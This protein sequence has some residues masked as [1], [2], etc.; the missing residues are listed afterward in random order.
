ML[1]KSFKF[2]RVIVSSSAVLSLC[3]ASPGQAAGPSARPVQVDV[4]LVLAVDVSWSMTKRELEI[5]RRGYAEAL[6]SRAVAK[7]V[8]SGPIGRIALTYIEW[9]GEYWHRTIVDWTLIENQ[10]ALKNFAGSLTIDVS[11]EWRKT[12]ISGAIDYAVQKLANNRFTSLRQ[13]IDVSGDGPNNDGRPVRDARAAAL[14]KGVTIN[15]LPLMTRDARGQRFRLEDLDEYYKHCVIGGPGAFIVPVRRW[16]EF[17]EAVRRKLV[18]ELAQIAPMP[19]RRVAYKGRTATGYDC[20]I[21]EKIWE[22]FFR[23]NILP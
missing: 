3:W 15:G 11:K 19:L 2:A 21:G 6:S 12:S 7:A 5:Q 8:A 22:E 16:E 10:Q 9:G 14:A 20:L 4:E 17:P 1:H 13:I 18:L 23:R